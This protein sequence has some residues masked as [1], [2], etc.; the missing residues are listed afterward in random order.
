MAPHDPHV[1]EPDTKAL[2]SAL[3]AINGKVPDVALALLEG[4]MTPQRQREF[5]DLLTELA[6]LLRAHAGGLV[7]PAGTSEPADESAAP[8][9]PP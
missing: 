8:S 2:L 7:I 6:E 4:R 1:L 9:P 5:A 3:A